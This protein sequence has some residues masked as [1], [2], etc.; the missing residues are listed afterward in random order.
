MAGDEHD[1]PALT[2]AV[3][4]VSSQMGMPIV[5]S[6]APGRDGRDSRALR[7]TPA[8]SSHIRDV[9]R[10]RHYFGHALCIR[11]KHNRG[12]SRRYRKSRRDP[13][14]F[15]IAITSDWKVSAAMAAVCAQINPLQGKCRKGRKPELRR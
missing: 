14:L 9:V 12:M 2:N 13:G 3:I 7:D 11:A 15:E 5:E 6:G 4:F 10:K 8:F 1:I